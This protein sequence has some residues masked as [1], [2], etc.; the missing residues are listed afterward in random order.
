MRMRTHGRHVGV[1][2]VALVA[3]LGVLVA[4]SLK[5]ETGQA[6]TAAPTASITQVVAAA[7]NLKTLT[8]LLQSTGLDKALAGGQ[9]TVFAP[10]DAAFAKI[11]EAALKQLAADPEALQA[12]LLYHAVAG[13]FDSAAAKTVSSLVTLDGT[14][15]GVSVVGDSLYVNNA[16]VVAGDAL[17]DNGVVHAIDTV[18]MPLDPS[19]LGSARVDYCAVAGNTTPSGNPIRPGRFLDLRDGQPEADFHYVGAQPANFLEGV[20]ITCRV[21]SSGFKQEGTAQPSLGVPAGVYPY[22]AKT[23]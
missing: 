17:A 1:G 5:A 9:Y 16:K 4:G 23:D 20:G 10:T 22:W 18:L 15:V 8:A 7:D 13:K 2:L 19:A 6:A 21:P 14:K 3:L 12:V 11:P